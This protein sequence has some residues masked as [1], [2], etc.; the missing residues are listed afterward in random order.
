VGGR[1]GEP[2]YQVN[3]FLERWIVESRNDVVG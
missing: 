3:I 2:V 1:V